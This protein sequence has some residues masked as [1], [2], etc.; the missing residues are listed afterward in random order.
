MSNEREQCQAHLDRELE[1]HLNSM[2]ENDYCG[3]D[4][5][6]LEVF[7][8]GFKL[9]FYIEG[10]ARLLTKP[11]VKNLVEYLNNWLK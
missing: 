5:G 4:I 10:Q 2:N 3:E 8:D 1:N 9:G 6:Q 11:Q 7:S